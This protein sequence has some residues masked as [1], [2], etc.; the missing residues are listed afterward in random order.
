[1]GAVVSSQLCHL[2][3]VAG[4]AFAL[5]AERVTHQYACAAGLRGGPGVAHVAHLDVVAL[6]DDARASALLTTPAPMQR[7]NQAACARLPVPP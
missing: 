3:A 7:L 5:N 1:M 6:D 2:N 4:S